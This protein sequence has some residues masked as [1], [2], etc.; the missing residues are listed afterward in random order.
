MKGRTYR[1]IEDEPLYPFGYGLSY[2]DISC[3]RASAEYKDGKVKIKAEFVNNGKACTDKV[4]VYIKDLESEFAV[5]NF[6][7]CGFE[8]ITLEKSEKKELEIEVAERAL[9]VV[10]NEGKRY[11]DSK[12]F[13][14]FVGVNAPDKTSVRLMGKAPVEIELNI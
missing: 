8:T 1:Y 3:T 5:P 13:K 2:G 7:L 12:R 14:L 4:Q 11:I 10:D 9:T 6:S